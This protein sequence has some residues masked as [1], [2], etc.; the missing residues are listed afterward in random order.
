MPRSKQSLRAGFGSY[1]QLLASLDWFRVASLWLHYY[2]GSANACHMH[3]VGLNAGHCVPDRS[4]ISH[5]ACTD[6]RCFVDLEPCAPQR[7]PFFLSTAIHGSVVVRF[8]QGLCTWPLL[9]CRPRQLARGAHALAL[10]LRSICSYSGLETWIP[11]TNQL[12]PGCRAEPLGQAWSDSLQRSLKS[13]MCQ[14]LL[15]HGWTKAEGLLDA[16]SCAQLRQEFQVYPTA[17]RDNSQ[18]M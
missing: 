11:A 16:H 13:D 1:Q 7:L 17:G 9:L 5:Q 2:R 8:W 15:Q 18:C 4:A 12:T 3:G 14:Q 10:S 6:Q